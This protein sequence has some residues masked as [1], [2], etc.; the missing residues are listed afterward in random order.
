ML[1]CMHCWEGYSKSWEQQRQNSL[2]SVLLTCREK[3]QK[4]ELPGSD[5]ESDYV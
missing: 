3:S 5:G 4:W 1:H 2:Q